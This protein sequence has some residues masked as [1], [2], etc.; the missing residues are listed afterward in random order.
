MSTL[1]SCLADTIILIY[2]LKCIIMCQ[3]S[4]LVEWCEI[5]NINC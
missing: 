5:A 2:I 4:V 1:G 3:Q